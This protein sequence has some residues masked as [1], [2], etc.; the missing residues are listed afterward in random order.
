[1]VPKIGLEIHAQLKT[2]SKLFCSCSTNAFGTAANTNICPVC[3]AEP[4]VLPVLN[5]KAVERLIEMGLALGCS[6]STW[7]R[8]ARK[9]YF[10]PDL[11]K[12]YQISQYEEPVAT[13]GK[14]SFF[15]SNERKTVRIT[16]IHLE[17]DAGKLMHALGSQ[18]LDFSLVDFN[19]AGMPLAETVTEPDFTNAQEVSDFLQALRATLRRLDVS[20][21]DLEKGEMRMDVNISLSPDG[22]TLGTKVEIKNLN[23]FKSARD[24]L[25]Y[26]INRQGELLKNGGK[27]SQETRLWDTKANQT[28]VLRSKEEASD[29]RYFPD[30]DLL[31]IVIDA[32]WQE[33][34]R[35]TLGEQ[36]IAKLERYQTELGFG[37]KEAQAM[38]Y[39]EDPAI[40][41]LFDETLDLAKGASGTIEAKTIANWILNDLLA[42][43]KDQEGQ[44]AS[45]EF[46][47]QRFLAF[48]GTIAAKGLPNKIAREIFLA[49]LA[50]PKLDASA[51]IEKSGFT[52]I[53]S[54]D[55]LTKLVQEAIA[56]NPKAVQEFLQGKEKAVGALMGAIMKATKGQIQPQKVQDLLRQ[57]LE[58]LKTKII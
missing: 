17:E 2:A 43:L 21:C 46:T 30:P 56:G 34:I 7:N 47:P 9:N 48:L 20:N 36:P 39:N 24:A 12:N 45:L 53:D 50:D 52:L 49:L 57:E 42:Y 58:K 25:E 55:Q 6:I 44:L 13:H 32:N 5:K 3:V 54:S 23:S 40:Q 10:Y 8:F 31:P 51:A 4:G 11:P 19:R 27:V 41:K 28:K 29:Y 18:E 22:D 26:E 35:L 33:K 14:F 16:R 1:M 15:S 37:L 38:I